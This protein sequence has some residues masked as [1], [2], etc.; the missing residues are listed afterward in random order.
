MYA[1][2]FKSIYCGTLRGNSHGL[3]VFTNLLANSSSDGFVDMHP[4]AIAGEVG[5][6]V[7]EVR[8]ALDH[9]EAPDPESRTPD[10]EGRRIIR[11]DEHRSWG[12]RIVNYAKYRAIR[13]E[14]D[15]R[16]Q[17]R[18]AQA[19]FR[20]KQKKK[21]ADSKQSKPSEAD[22]SRVKPQ[23]AQAE[24]EAEVLRT[25]IVHSVVAGPQV[26]AG[27]AQLEC[28]HL[29]I[30]DLWSKCLPELSRHDPELWAGTRS[31]HLR[32]RWRERCKAKAWKTEREGVDY[33]ARLFEWIRDS[34]WLMGRVGGSDG[35]AFKLT[36][37]WLVMPSNWAKVL[38]GK[39]H[40]G[41][42]QAAPTSAL[43]RERK[44]LADQ[45]MGQYAPGR[46]V[47]VTPQP[48]TLEV[49]NG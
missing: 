37:E 46:T 25:N 28:P 19:R 23:K 33:F 31:D 24:A 29:A 6:T 12:W 10:E 47:D 16:E 20:E 17:N 4:A 18:Q 11:T 3:L 27:S 5:L 9:L 35:R 1:K 40:G 14:D 39:Y 43:H 32:A 34:D 49:G 22:E 41:N 2:L 8:A 44:A 21:A 48:N 38:E 36:L 7:A 30:L 15:R 42:E 13:N 45:W 26:D